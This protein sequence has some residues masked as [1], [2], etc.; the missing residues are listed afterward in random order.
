MLPQHYT[1]IFTVH[2]NPR[3]WNSA[4]HRLLKLF[5]SF[6]AACRLGRVES[7]QVGLRSVHWKGALCPA[8]YIFILFV[9]S[10]I[11]YLLYFIH[12]IFITI[13]NLFSQNS[14]LYLF[15]RSTDSPAWWKIIPDLFH[16][17]R[18]QCRVSYWPI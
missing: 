16:Q 10:F 2:W 17:V 18:F 13:F 14:W 7:Y 5:T 11:F 6:T 4:C 3:R 1:T 15:L 9:S 12:V 8:V